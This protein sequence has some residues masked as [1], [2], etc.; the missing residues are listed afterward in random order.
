[1]E[2]ATTIRAMAQIQNSRYY[3]LNLQSYNRH[4]SLEF[5]QHGGTVELEKIKNWILFLHNLVE[6][7]K[8]IKTTAAAATLDS[9]S[10]FQQPEIINYIQTRINNFA[11]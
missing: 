6:Y 3:K 4:E 8:K 2:S 11:A 7:S 5:R 10:K 9:L 1:M